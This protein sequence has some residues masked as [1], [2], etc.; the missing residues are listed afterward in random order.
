MW[1]I[2][3]WLSQHDQLQHGTQADIIKLYAHHELVAYCLLENY[4]ARTDKR[5]PYKGVVYQDLG[6]IHFVTVDKHRNKGYASL[7]AN[8]LYE[9]KVE[10]M[11]KA[12]HN[13]NIN[14][15]F[16]T[17][18]G[19]A[20]PIMA[21]TNIAAHHLVKQFYS[22]QSFATKVGDYLNNHEYHYEKLTT[23]YHHTA[24]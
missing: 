24:Y 10:P 11:L 12:H 3:Q 19:R 6:V 22:D 20:A 5:T 8:A 18:T 13:H 17:A 16:F 23:S 21:R 15:A 9:S 4:H 14:H 7:L 2:F 1:N